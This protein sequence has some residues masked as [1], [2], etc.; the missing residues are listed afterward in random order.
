MSI[1]KAVYAASLDPIT[2]G[3][4]NIIERTAPLYDELIVLIAV[5]PRKNYTFT[6][7]DRYKMTKAA[8]SHLHNVTVYTCIGRYVVEYAAELGAQA[9][10]RGLR[11]FKDMEDEQTL[12]IENRKIQPN[13]ETI[14]IPCL[15]ELMHVSSSMV[16]GHIGIDP[17]WEKQVARSVPA[18]VVALLREKY[19]LGKARKH[20]DALMHALGDPRGSESVFS[21]LKDSYGMP[22]RAYHTLKH[23]VSMLDEAAQFMIPDDRDA[24]ELKLAIWFHDAIYIPLESNNEERSADAAEKF[25]S[26]LG[27]PQSA[28]ARVK[29]LVMATKHMGLHTAPDGLCK[30]IIDLDLAILG[31]PEEEFDEYEIAIRREYASVPIDA[32]QEG[33]A[34]ILQSFLDRP[35]IYSM[36]CFRDKY[37]KTARE[38]IARSIIRLQQ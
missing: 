21:F 20:W 34:R 16:K 13:I 9:I 4:I 11:N 10:I 31:K 25:L 26:P 12:A 6:P 3:H 24:S 33:R 19:I 14:W 37:E 18:P 8:V 15:P 32:Y 38:N 28:I 29:E 27:L 36:Q 22:G 30:T 17:G 23:I 35:Q 1:R 7:E 5:D 2:K